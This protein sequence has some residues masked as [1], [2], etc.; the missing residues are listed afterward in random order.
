MTRP[1]VLWL[2][3]GLGLGGAERLLTSVAAGIDPERFEVDVAYLLPWK[4][5]FVAELERH[6]V[7]AVCLGA[8]RTVDPR[9]VLRLRSL[10]RRR[11]YAIVHTH[12]PVPAAAARMLARSPTR[13]VHTEHNVWDRYRWPTR[14]AN[15]FTYT[16]NDVAI[17]VSDAVADSIAPPRWLPGKPPPVETLLHGVDLAGVP[18]GVGARHA[19][20]EA[21][22]IE[23]DAHVVG[24]VANFTPKKDHTGLLAAISQVRE[25]VPGVVLLLVGSGPL[26]QDL[27]REVA[28][29]R[30]QDTV[31]FLG[32]RDDVPTLLPALDVFVLGSRFEGL[33]ISL[34]EAMAAEV[35]CV[36]TRVGGI[37]EAITDGVQGRL[38]PPGEPTR[39][40]AALTEMLGDDE[41]RA[42][43]ARA[44]L[45]RV[46]AEFSID[47]AVGRTQELYDQLLQPLLDPSGE[48]R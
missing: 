29:R 27:R 18:R 25:Q 43:L 14:A 28:E 39:L 33:P 48:P 15:A 26:E 2:T 44:G 6:G 8:R 17:A 36:A 24:T 9:W 37:P 34:L 21:L 5:A 47:R 4:D 13:L 38:V 45:A 30:L 46:S 41:L 16:R 23:A 3:K 19:A 10:L 11:R 1:R 35:A 7:R 40:A 42:D 20:R 31:R 32:S 22:G 12:S